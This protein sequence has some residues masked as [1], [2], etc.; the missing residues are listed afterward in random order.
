MRLGGYGPEGRRRVLSSPAGDE[1][2]WARTSDTLLKRHQVAGQNLPT[3]RFLGNFWLVTAPFQP[4]RDGTCPEDATGPPW[5]QLWRP[6]TPETK[7][8]SC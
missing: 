8:G 6:V 2:C 3:M 1:P 7:V 4:R 5:P